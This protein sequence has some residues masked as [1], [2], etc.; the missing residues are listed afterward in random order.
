[1]SE[2]TAGTRLGPYEI[3]SLLG[4]GG[5]GEVY[6]AH[7]QRL[8]RDVAIKIL[9]DPCLADAERRARFERE[10]RL[11]A[12]LNH[13]HVG[14]IYGVED[15]GGTRA[16]VLELVEGPTLAERLHRWT[17]E[18]GRESG[19]G[20]G[21]PIAEVLSV[22]RQIAEA[23]EAAHEKGIVHRDLKPA[24]IK[25][26]SHGVVKVID[27]GL[28]TAASGDQHGPDPR[29]ASGVTQAGTRP[30]MILGTPAYMSPEQARGKPVDKRSDIWSFGCVLYEMLT[31]RPP[32]EG[33][34]IADALVGVLEGEPDWQAL[35]EATPAS[36]ERLLRR[37]LEKDHTRRLRDIGEARVEIDNAESKAPLGAERT[38]RTSRDWMTIVV[39][40]F[41]NLS[42]DPEQEYFSDGLTDETISA[43]GQMNPDRIRVVARTSSMAYKRTTKTAAQIGQELGAEY[44][45]ESS[46]RREAQRVRIST[47]LIRVEDQTQVWS[48]TYNRTPDSFLGVQD[49]IG[50]AIASQV[51]VRLSLTQQERLS[52]P[53]TRD[54]EAYDLYLHGQYHWHRF[55]MREAIECF[56]AAVAK[57]PSFGLAHAGLAV[58]YA[59]LPILADAVPLEYL[60]KSRL[61]ATKARSLDP[62]LAEAHAATGWVDF[63]LG[64]DWGKAEQA[65]RRAIELSPNDAQVHFY[66]AHVLSNSFRH[67]EAIATIRKGRE[68]DPLS[69]VMHSLHGQF[70]FDA[71]RYSEALEPIQRAIAID[72]SFFHG[73]EILSRV[74]LQTGDLEGA[75]E[76]CEKAYQLSGGMLF[77]F[78]RK[79]YV[80]AVAG[81]RDE[82]E[83][84]MARLQAIS[85]ERFVAPFHF[86]LVHAGL[87]NRDET[88]TCLEHAFDVRAVHLVLLPTDPIWDDFRH[89]ARFRALL[90]KWR[91]P[92]PPVTP[93]R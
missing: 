53:P 16:L 65:Y 6:R 28:A 92:E 51:Q 66:L 83:Q 20:T 60:E 8:G 85:T 29:Q 36:V 74:Y 62:L 78:A 87:G 76:E 7:D 67:D 50:H 52:R 46:V 61:A 17:A 54:P 11:L 55:G 68:L 88:L 31:G 14:S 47:Q 27:F 72:P 40:P 23:L 1:M 64:W 57:D 82:A 15:Q 56:E 24:N 79:G 18:A 81:R 5:M 9:S 48:E 70:L 30:G 45:L 42:S 26:T 44:L 49:E 12:A 59:G 22:A 34:T 33:E 4:E 73:H 21:L 89:E 2:L 69:P 90:K 84:V 91:F 75:L 13:P 86:A 3:L 10:A 80:L 35:P 39:L 93:G 58:A 32:F 38:H 37:C 41:H 63:W 77:A 71:R 43:L 25:V 19:R